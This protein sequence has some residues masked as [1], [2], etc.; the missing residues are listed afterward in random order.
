LTEVTYRLRLLRWASD[1]S[2]TAKVL[3]APACQIS[4]MMPPTTRIKTMAIQKMSAGPYPNPQDDLAD[5]GAIAAD[6][7]QP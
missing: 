4:F 1:R 5:I 3:T 6:L 2:N 7:A